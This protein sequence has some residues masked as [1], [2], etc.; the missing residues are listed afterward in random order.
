MKPPEAAPHIF[1]WAV[2]TVRQSGTKEDGTPI[3]EPAGATSEK[4]TFTWT[5]IG[6]PATATPTPSP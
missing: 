3:Y 5:G 1:E 6:V 4:R 2:V